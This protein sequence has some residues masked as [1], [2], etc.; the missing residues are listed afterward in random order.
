MGA[1]AVDGWNEST[2]KQLSWLVS[3]GG[4]GFGYAEVSGKVARLAALAQCLPTAGAHLRAIFLEATDAGI[5]EAIPLEDADTAIAELKHSYGLEMA[6]DGAIA[7]AREAR[8][9]LH[10][11]FQP[12]WGLTGRLTKAI[13]ERKVAEEFASLKCVEETD[14]A[15]AQRL[16]RRD[17][18]S[19][20]RLRIAALKA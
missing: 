12:I 9:N 4:C 16:R 11:A 17:P 18:E 7:V 19:A 2:E 10:T 3:M 14:R 5:F 1:N 6:V 8:L 20:Q 15:N 13:L